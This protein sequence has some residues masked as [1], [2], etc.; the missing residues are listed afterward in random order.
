MEEKQIK[1]Y[2]DG[3]LQ[4]VKPINDQFTLCKCYVMATGTNDNGMDI[5]KEVVDAALPTLPYVPVV[6]HLI[7]EDGELRMGGHDITLELDADGKYTFKA[8]TIPFGVVPKECNPH[9][10]QVID[11]SE[12][13]TYLVADVILWTGRYPELLD[14]KYS[15]DL[16]FA[17]SMEIFA[18]KVENSGKYR[19]VGEMQFTGLCLLGKSDDQGKNILPCFKSARVEPYMFAA[20]DGWDEMLRQFKL[21]FE[22]I[23]AAESVAK[24]GRME[25]ETVKRIM[26]ECGLTE[27]ATLPFELAEDMTE[28]ELRAKIAE[29]AAKDDEPEQVGEEPAPEAAAEPEDVAT[30]EEEKEEPAE[31]VKAEKFSIDRTYE[32][33]RCALD[34]AVGELCVHSETAYVCYCLMD[35]DG[36]YAYAACHIAGVGIAEECY[37]V[38]IPYEFVD[39]HCVLNTAAAEKVRQIW[40]TKADEDKLEAERAKL[41]E[42]I[43]YK[44]DKIQREKEQ[45]YASIIAEFT[46]LGDLEEYKLTVKDA[47]NFESADALKEKLYAIRGKNIK[48]ATDK[49]NSSSARIPVGFEL[50][51]FNTKTKQD[52]E[53][54]FMNRYYHPANK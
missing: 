46:D 47:L 52:E 25:N 20:Q 44:A 43:E 49:K 8:L 24:G 32:E 35:F 7:E 39:S 17:Q 12:E 13:K 6:G 11:N 48:I 42:L 3:K 34:M 15:D 18:R 40:L 5:P 33:K 45:T 38:R 23:Y 50:K 31:E 30:E 36:I 10:E 19:R 41:N 21:E 14:T 29:F 27:D 2:F 28:E 4:P 26:V 1:A 37:A 22:K 9:Y 51:Q 54:D 53:E 16:Y